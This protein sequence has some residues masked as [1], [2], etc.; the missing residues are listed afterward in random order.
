MDFLPKHV[1][2][3][4][5]EEVGINIGR[6]ASD[7]MSAADGEDLAHGVAA[8][9]NTILVHIGCPHEVI[10]LHHLNDDNIVGN[11]LQQFCIVLI[12]PTL[13]PNAPQHPMVPERGK[14]IPDFILVFSL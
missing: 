10:L 2:I 14:I 6:S 12:E 7:E 4:G 5:V 9:E 1:D 8:A 13:L 11:T 3:G